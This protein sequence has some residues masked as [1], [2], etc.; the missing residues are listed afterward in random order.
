MDRICD[1]EYIQNS[2]IIEIFIDDENYKKIE[3]KNMPYLNDFMLNKINTMFSINE[4]KVML[5][6]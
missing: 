5:N 3:E 1:R 2:K 6:K 4:N